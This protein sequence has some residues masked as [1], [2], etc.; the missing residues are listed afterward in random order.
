MP[1]PCWKY[2]RPLIKLLLVRWLGDKKK[3]AFRNKP[4]SPDTSPEKIEY[5]V[6]TKTDERIYIQA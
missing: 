1:N 2:A 6:K 5:E 3:K 4:I